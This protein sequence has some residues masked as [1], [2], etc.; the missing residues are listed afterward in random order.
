MS[1]EAG[2]IAII[3]ARGGSKRLPRK[4]LLDVQG[5]P[6][7][8]WTI[9][10]A[11]ESNL[12]SHVYVSTEDNEIA[13]ISKHF[14]A[15]VL[16]RPPH[17]ATDSATIV[18]V[19]LYHLGRSECGL[20]APSSLFCLYP[21][22]PLRTSS[23]LEKIARILESHADAQ[24]VVAVTKYM[25]YAYQAMAAD[26]EFIRPFWPDLNRLRSDRLPKLVAGN[27]STYAIKI[28]SFLKQKS[29]IVEQGMYFH[30]MELFRSIDVDTED[31]LVMLRAIAAYLKS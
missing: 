11:K 26:G 10:A 17:L 13:E 2:R 23:D 31:D 28:E 16:I 15:E 30:E 9:E 29:F 1:T 12:F 19:C 20:K 6:M 14:G 25:H 22:A 24:A 7:I 18:E 5:K 27:G 8:A 3:P 21:T 4:N